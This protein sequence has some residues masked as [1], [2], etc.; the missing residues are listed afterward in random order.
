ME[1]SIGSVILNLNMYKD[2]RIGYIKIIKIRKL[3]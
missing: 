1:Q 3:S 2:N